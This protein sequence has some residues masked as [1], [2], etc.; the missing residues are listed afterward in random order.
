MK[1]MI[2]LG[3][4]AAVIIC[5][6][7]TGFAFAQTAATVP[8]LSSGKSDGTL[9]LTI[10]LRHDQSRNLAEINDQLWK[11][12]YF[13]K[14]PPDG[15]E[16][17]SWY[18]AMGVGQIITLRLPPEKLRAVNVALEQTAWGPYRTDFYATYDY[19]QLAEQ[20]RKM[21]REKKH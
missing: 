21:M 7:W 12:G 3:T 20:Q 8:P 5:I 9:L 16:I 10:F 15:V 4:C 6:L 17:V 1:R 19:K 13:D 14:F 11:N 2:T 18:V